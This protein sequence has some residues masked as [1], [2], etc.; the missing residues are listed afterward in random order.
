MSIAACLDLL[1]HLLPLCKDHSIVALLYQRMTDFLN[2]DLN[3]QCAC[4]IL[5][6]LTYTRLSV[7][8]TSN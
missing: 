4:S 6:V 2:D 1:A 7:T 3:D 8:T 5:N